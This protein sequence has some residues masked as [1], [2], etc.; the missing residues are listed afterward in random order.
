VF[1]THNFSQ[2]YTEMNSISHILTSCN[3]KKAISGLTH[4]SPSHTTQYSENTDLVQGQS[5]GTGALRPIKRQEQNY[6]Y[7][8]SERVRSLCTG[9]EEGQCVVLGI[10]T[11]R[12]TNPSIQIPIVI[13]SFIDFTTR[14]VVTV[15][16]PRCKVLL[17]KTTKRDDLR[18]TAVQF[19]FGFN[20][21]RNTDSLRPNIFVV[22][23]NSST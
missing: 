7:L 8:W 6:C 14:K 4:S 17:G 16:P 12:P 1:Y 9:Q 10:E 2:T 11:N 3:L 23:R 18:G 22:F 13:F 5:L 15:T 20:L 21:G 19:V